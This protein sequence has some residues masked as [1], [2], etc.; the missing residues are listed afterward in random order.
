MAAKTIAKLEEELQDLEKKRASINVKIREKKE[1][2]AHKKRVTLDKTLGNLNEDQMAF[3]I[4]LA[5][6]AD[7]EKIKTVKELLAE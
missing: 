1:Q 6:K 3:L 2:I 4:E 7:A 5:E